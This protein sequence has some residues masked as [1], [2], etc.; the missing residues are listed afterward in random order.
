M[1]FE[2]ATAAHLSGICCSLFAGIFMGYLVPKS[3]TDEAHKFSVDFFTVLAELAES[4]VFFQIGLN[5]VIFNVNKDTS[6]PWMFSIATFL[7][8]VVAR[9]VAVCVLTGCM[10]IRRKKTRFTWQHI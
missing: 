8:C 3:Q 7:L 9:I 5:A 6:F 4:V 2:L 1:S 10:N